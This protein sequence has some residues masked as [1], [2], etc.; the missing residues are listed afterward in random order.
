M[1]NFLIIEVIVST[2]LLIESFAAIAHACYTNPK[3]IQKYLKEFDATGFYSKIGSMDNDYYAQMLSLPNI[4]SISECESKE[5][6]L[7]GIRDVIEFLNEVK[8]YYFSNLNLFNSY[9]HGFRLFPMSTFGK[10]DEQVSVI[11]YFSRSHKQDGVVITRLDKD[12]LKHEN[13][14]NDVKYFIRIIL[15]NH[16]NKLK[17]PENWDVTVPLRRKK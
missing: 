4:D 16:E 15:K 11:M 8:E 7:N 6:I 2:M 17:K 9:K 12:P 10:N 13:L 3:N 14:A 5:V 1:L